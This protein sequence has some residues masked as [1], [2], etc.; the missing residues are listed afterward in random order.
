MQNF[1]GKQMISG[2]KFHLTALIVVMFEIA[3]NRTAA[4]KFTI[5]IQ[6]AP[7]VRPH[8]QSKTRR[9]SK[10]KFPPEQ[11]IVRFAPGNP[12]PGAR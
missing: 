2:G 1:G 3:A 12:A 9:S 4:E 11:R 7:A 8:Q 5:Q 10:M 6:I